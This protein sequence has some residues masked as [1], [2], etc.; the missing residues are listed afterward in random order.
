MQ[1]LE[2][3]IM[4]LTF[5]TEIVLIGFWK[6]RGARSSRR[7]K[8]EENQYLHLTEKKDISVLLFW[9][10]SSLRIVSSFKYR[11]KLFAKYFLFVHQLNSLSLLSYNSVQNIRDC[12]WSKSETIKVA[13]KGVVALFFHSFSE[14]VNL[15]CFLKKE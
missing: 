15:N 10:I 9:T 11:K 8:S 14:F 6:T 5:S 13:M 2:N 12:Y 3:G 1:K 4:D 7:R